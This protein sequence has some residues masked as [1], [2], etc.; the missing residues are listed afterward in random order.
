M[1]DDVA[2]VQDDAEP[3]PPVAAET[4][5]RRQA[6]DHESVDRP[7]CPVPADPCNFL[8]RL[9]QIRFSVQAG[10]TPG[11]GNYRT[12][13]STPSG[14]RISVRAP[15][16]HLWLGHTPRISDTHREE[17]AKM[18]GDNRTA[19]GAEHARK[20][21]APTEVRCH[22]A[23]PPSASTQRYHSSC[24]RHVP[25]WLAP[26]RCRDRDGLDVVDG[27]A[28][29]LAPI[30]QHRTLRP[31]HISV[32]K[33]WAFN[34]LRRSVVWVTCVDVRVALYPAPMLIRSRERSELGW[35][36]HVVC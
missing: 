22:M 27:D 17:G 2:V 19:A 25:R 23:T 21:T 11:Q 6:I 33:V 7:C 14:T 29:R 34:I 16:H 36:I 4:A 12:R 5:A 9:V 24:R 18:C 28:D 26:R 35:M 30:G 8:R 1:A 15:S 20:R 32:R 13:V 3:P 10:S 31:C